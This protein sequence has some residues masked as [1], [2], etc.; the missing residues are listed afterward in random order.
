MISISPD[1][2]QVLVWAP[3]PSFFAHLPSH[4]AQMSA[5]HSFGLSFHSLPCHQP[6]K[7]QALV[8]LSFQLGPS[9][10]LSVSSAQTSFK[11]SSGLSFHRILFASS[12][13]DELQVLIWL[14]VFDLAF[15]FCL[16]FHL[17]F[18]SPFAS[19]SLS[20]PPG[21]LYNKKNLFSIK[22]ILYILQIYKNSKKPSKFK[23]DSQSRSHNMY[24][25]FCD[26]SH[27]DTLKRI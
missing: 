2:R 13:P 16:P 21:K 11:H 5:C 27:A 6:D 17:M 8:W 19:T 7:L 1:K 26:P 24:K 23:N 14:F 25:E 18:S 15:F 12:R 10:S 22:L 20:P 9:T 3:N 4:I